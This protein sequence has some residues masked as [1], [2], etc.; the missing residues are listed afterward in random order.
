M[1]GSEVRAAAH[2]LDRR[3]RR[4]TW[5]ILLI[6]AVLA[7][8]GGWGWARTTGDAQDQQRRADQAIQSAVQLCLQVRQ[9]GGACIKDPAELRGE[10][11]PAGVPGPIGPQGP[12]GA[13]GDP[14]PAGPAGIQ[15]VGGDPGPPGPAGQ[16][17]PA[18]PAGAQGAPPASWTWTF[19]GITY[20]CTRDAGS[21]DN[22]ATYTCNSTTAQTFKH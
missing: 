22:A 11:G 13:T 9:M 10:P 21:P 15:G 4:R 3:G 5:V 6:T 2:R 16:Q 14:G 20:V 18:G 17:G 19:L 12:T 1:T 7:G 8:L